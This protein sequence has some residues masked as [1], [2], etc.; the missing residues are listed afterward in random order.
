MAPM[1]RASPRW[2]P[3]LPVRMLRALRNPIRA[4][5]S[6]LSVISSLDDSPGAPSREL[7]EGA[8]LA[9]VNAFD[10][11]LSR[12]HG[13]SAS[14]LA[15]ISVHPGEHY[16]LLASIVERLQPALVLEIG[17]FTGL[18]ALAMMAT[19]PSHSRLISYDIV[20]WE[21]LPE[22]ALRQA[23]FADGRLEQRIGNLAQPEYFQQNSSLLREARI[24]FV[25]GPK[26][27]N[28]EP[29]FFRFLITL[30][31]KEPC[32]VIFDDIRLWAM[33]DFWRNIAITKF[34]A[35]SV[36]HW[37]GTGIC[38]LSPSSSI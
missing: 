32:W 30:P 38:L 16:R 24:I 14:A 2:G 36:G 17:T 7:V 21:R 22:P 26:D 11:D 29:Q 6:E 34:D 9:G 31:R 23:D 18:S 4:R 13:R 10:I 3:T 27:G 5:H 12:L 25:D 20:P 33:L 8:V 15:S 19:L 1:L 28:F 37:S 35:T